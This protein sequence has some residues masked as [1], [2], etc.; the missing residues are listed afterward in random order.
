MEERKSSIQRTTLET[1]ILLEL[2]FRKFIAVRTATHRSR[3]PFRTSPQGDLAASSRYPV[4]IQTTTSN[5]YIKISTFMGVN[6][7]AD[8]TNASTKIM[9]APLGFPAD[10]LP[11]WA[12]S[13]PPSFGRYGPSFA[14]A[15][16]VTTNANKIPPR[17]SWD[18]RS[19]DTIKCNIWL[20]SALLCCYLYFYRLLQDFFLILS[21]KNRKC[22]QLPL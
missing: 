3:N 16:T 5:R 19:P 2:N 17:A 11:S 6:R 12:N 18:V 21:Q 13:L 9:P 20:P 4:I 7:I 22:N 15:S 8:I 14:V 10:S 1:N